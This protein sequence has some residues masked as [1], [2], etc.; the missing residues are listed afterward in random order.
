LSNHQKRQCEK[1]LTMAKSNECNGLIST[2]MPIYRP[3]N[4]VLNPTSS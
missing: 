3:R 2:A 1:R 4:A